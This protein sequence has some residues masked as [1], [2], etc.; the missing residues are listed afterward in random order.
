MVDCP[1]TLTPAEIVVRFGD[2]ASVNC[3]TSAA[4]VVGMGWEAT[5]GGTGFENTSA[6]TW[7][8]AKLEDWAINPLCFLTLEDKQCSKVAAVTLYS[9]YKSTHYLLCSP[10][11]DYPTHV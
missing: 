6:V 1:L 7:R 4:D 11:G 10:Q 3:S 9:E 8:V 5:V 2:P